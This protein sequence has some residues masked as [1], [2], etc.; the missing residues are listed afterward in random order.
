VLFGKHLQRDL[1]RMMLRGQRF[2][3]YVNQVM[4]EMG[5]TLKR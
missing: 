4:A 3:K 2:A 1:E 5:W